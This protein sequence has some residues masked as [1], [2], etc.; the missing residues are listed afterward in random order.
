MLQIFLTHLDFRGK[1]EYNK[2]VDCRERQSLSLKSYDILLNIC[3]RI[4]VG[5]VAERCQ[6]QI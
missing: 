2:I 1:I 3:T 4:E 5:D 6:W